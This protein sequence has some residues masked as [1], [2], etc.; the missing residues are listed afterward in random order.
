MGLFKKNN[1]DENQVT[2]V[3]ELKRKISQSG[4]PSCVEDIA[5]KELDL[6][7]KMNPSTA[8][9]TIILTYIEYLTSLPWNK[10]T[11]DNLDLE[12]AERI[13][14]ERHYGLYGV[15]NRILE[16][17]AVKILSSN[18]TPRILVIDDEEIA[19]K[20]IEHVLTKENYNVITAK[21]GAEAFKI[22]DEQEFEIVLTDIKMEGLDGFAV[23][24]KVKAKY[25]NTKVIMI[26]AYAAVDNAVEAIKRGVVST[27]LC[28]F[29]IER[30]I[31][32]YLAYFC[33]S[34]AHLH[35]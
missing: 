9:Y 11:S 1:Q 14:N 16:H 29:F 3:E 12:K 15:K 19:R 2:I 23:L 35:F 26:T 5:L 6:L 34:P 7:S 27:F 25:P 21:N 33:M 30:Q 31:R 20:N 28:K 4:M 8:E 13:L 24:E 17:L 10:K 32:M 18:R 22:L